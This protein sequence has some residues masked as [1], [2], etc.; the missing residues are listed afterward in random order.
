[1]FEDNKGNKDLS[2]LRTG[3]FERGRESTMYRDLSSPK[4]IGGV[5]II[6]LAISTFNFKNIILLFSTLTAQIMGYIFIL[7]SLY[8][9]SKVFNNS[10]IFNQALIGMTFQ[11]VGGIIAFGYTYLQLPFLKGLIHFTTVLGIVGV[12]YTSS[13]FNLMY[14]YTKVVFYRI[15][16]FANPIAV[17]LSPL[18]FLLSEEVA[19]EALSIL[20]LALYTILMIAFYTTPTKMKED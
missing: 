5:G 7:V 2:S 16:A 6:L 4:E 18:F 14:R 12:L 11:I 3:Q 10:K 1:M 15:F 20:L 19:M 13:S 8:K 9:F 17:V